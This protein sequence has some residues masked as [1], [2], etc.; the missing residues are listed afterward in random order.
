MSDANRETRHSSLSQATI[1]DRL[2]APEPNFEFLY[3]N[4][5]GVG[6]AYMSRFSGEEI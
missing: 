1:R 3:P 6:I 5:D 4:G 2:E